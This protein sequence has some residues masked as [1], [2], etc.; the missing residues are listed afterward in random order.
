MMLVQFILGMEAGAG[1]GSN[2]QPWKGYIFK[3]GEC[4]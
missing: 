3:S 1:A 4:N 2:M